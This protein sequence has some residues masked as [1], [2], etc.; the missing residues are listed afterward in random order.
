MRP[1]FLRRFVKSAI[2]VNKPDMVHSWLSESGTTFDESVFDRPT[3]GLFSC[4]PDNVAEN[5]PEA[6]SKA[7]KILMTART[8][9]RISFMTGQLV[10]LA[11]DAGTP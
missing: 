8:K 1:I 6:L 11:R 3:Q 4:T 9:H 5:W 2:T 10:P 7:T